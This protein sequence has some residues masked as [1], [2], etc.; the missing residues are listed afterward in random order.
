MTTTAKDKELTE[1]LAY[2]MIGTP[3]MTDP[4]TAAEELGFKLDTE[5]FDSIV[6]ICTCCEWVCSQDECNE[7]ASGQWVCDQCLAEQEE[8]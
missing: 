2:E 3:G 4:S 5:I 1:K 7:D 8:L 6:F